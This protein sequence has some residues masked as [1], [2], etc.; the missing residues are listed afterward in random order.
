MSSYHNKHCYNTEMTKEILYSIIIPHRNCPDLLNR[1][2]NSIPERDNIQIIVVD[3]NS[4]ENKRPSIDRKDVEVILLN[5]D[6]SRGAG[7]AR[8]VGME[9]AVG[10]WLLFADADDFYE[11]GFTLVL[12]KYKDTDCDV[13]YFNYKYV[14]SSTLIKLPS[15]KALKYISIYDGSE[16]LTERIKYKTNVPWGKMI[17]RDF[18]LSYNMQYEEISK[19]NDTFFSYQV[20]YYSKRIAIDKEVIYIYTRFI[21]SITNGR[22]SLDVYKQ[23]FKN[24]FKCRSFFRFIDHPDYCNSLLRIFLGILKR[25]GFCYWLQIIWMFISN[26][27]EIVAEKDKYVNHFTQATK[28]K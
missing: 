2:V 25:E 23:S 1:C 12:D 24:S 20:A 22:K 7:H 15:P 21:G 16:D 11:E 6:L 26:Y 13:I 8:N 17:R 5:A 28:V 10:K 14:D 19:G 4:D 3:D 9:K 27:P 18:V